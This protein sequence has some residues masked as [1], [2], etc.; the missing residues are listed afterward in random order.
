[1]NRLFQ[2]AAITLFLAGC[3]ER[4]PKSLGQPFDGTPVAIAT[5]AGT[6]SPESSNMSARVVLHGRMTQKCP[7]A[8]CWFMLHDETGTIKVD[9]KNAGF[10][11]VDIPLQSSIVV[12]GYLMTNGAEKIIDA[13]GLRY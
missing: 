6:R 8:G 7:V 1:V 13:T 9:T 2:L 11:V 4:K 10:V 12:A 3:A 5:L